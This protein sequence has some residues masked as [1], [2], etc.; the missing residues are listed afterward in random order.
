MR[1][2][3]RAGKRLG[4][5][6]VQQRG[7]GIITE[8]MGP[9]PAVVDQLVGQNQ[10]ARRQGR[11]DAADGIDRNHLAHAGL[12]QR[13]DIGPVVD[14]VRRNAVRIAVAGQEPGGY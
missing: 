12:A 2:A 5:L 1:R 14:P 7:V 13:I 3:G 10:R 11:V 4:E 8:T 6:D 9:A